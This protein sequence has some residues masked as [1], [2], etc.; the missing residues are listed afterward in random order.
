MLLNS[1]ATSSGQVQFWISTRYGLSD[2]RSAGMRLPK[3]AGAELVS[4]NNKFLV[5]ILS[6]E[7]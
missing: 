7:V 1:K 2:F 3:E 6:L 5:R 4:Y